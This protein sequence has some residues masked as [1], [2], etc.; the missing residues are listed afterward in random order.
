MEQDFSQLYFC[1]T[2]SSDS[3]LP[4][5]KSLPLDSS[6]EMLFALGEYNNF[7]KPPE[8]SELF[9]SVSSTSLTSDMIY[10]TSCA[11]PEKNEML[12][13]DNEE[14]GCFLDRGNGFQS[15]DKNDLLSSL[16]DYPLQTSVCEPIT[17]SIAAP[18][19]NCLQH[20][21]KTEDTSE[22]TLSEL[23]AISFDDIESIIYN[24]LLVDVKPI[25]SAVTASLTTS[26]SHP[27][28]SKPS[29]CL[30]QLLSGNLLA[31]D[32]TLHSASVTTQGALR[33]SPIHEQPLEL[34]VKPML[35]SPT[36]AAQ[37]SPPA[38]RAKMAADKP[39]AVTSRQRTVSGSSS[40]SESRQGHSDTTYFWQYNTQAKG[41]KGQ[42]LCKGLAANDPHKI[43]SFEDP[44]FD[45]KLSQWNLR[46]TGKARRGDGNDIAPNSYRL[47]QIGKELDKLN[48]L[49]D[50]ITPEELPIG[51]QP[52]AKRAKNKYAS[53]ACRLK[54]KAQHEANKL[55]LFGLEQEHGKSEF[56]VKVTIGWVNIK[57]E[58]S[59]LELVEVKVRTKWVRVDSSCIV[60]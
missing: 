32:P 3:S 54:R 35:H 53:R 19:N 42:R 29:P 5:E 2:P 37:L 13:D 43:V 33:L 40:S 34:S 60:S 47:Y 27:H 25:P 59:R 6:L 52:K 58:R 46:H 9:P 55:K 17:A 28:A 23:N 57:R 31:S 7:S 12:F 51:E 15:M 48:T 16:E 49:L 14:I 20:V 39:A 30:Q 41:P 21:C 24:D 11:L 22:P 38:K 1:G 26:V 44:V 56:K 10:S 8:L 18:Q 45:P 4:A 36:A 50:G